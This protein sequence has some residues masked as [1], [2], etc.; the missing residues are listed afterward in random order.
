MRTAVRYYTR[1]GNT[2]KLAKAAAEAVGVTAASVDFPLEERVDIL[3]LCCSYYAF[4]V[5]ASVKEFIKK[6]AANIVRIVCIGSSAMMKSMYKP[7]KRAADAAGVEVAREEFHC[8]GRFK[9]AH[10]GR[11]DADDLAQAAEFA[12]ATLMKY[13]SAGND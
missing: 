11:P 9:M 10:K 8:R 4:D 2:Q 6:N 13:R 3:F 1:S 5:D 7:V 12:K